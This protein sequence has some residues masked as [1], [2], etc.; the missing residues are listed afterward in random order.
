MRVTSFFTF[1]FTA[2]ATETVGAQG[3]FRG[4]NNGNHVRALFEEVTMSA[5]LSLSLPFGEVTMSADLSLSLPFDGVPEPA[6]DPEPSGKSGKGSSM[7][8]MGKSGKGSSM[9]SMGKSGKGGSMMT[10]KPTT[11]PTPPPTLTSMQKCLLGLKLS[12]FNLFQTEKYN[13]WMDNAT[14]FELAETGV[15]RKLHMNLILVFIERPHHD[16]LL[17]APLLHNPKLW[18][19]PKDIAEYVLFTITP[20]VVLKYESLVSTFLS[21]FE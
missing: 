18:K 15:R 12:Q 16:S 7:M 10:K 5:D 17:I 1:L 4:G 21:T 19:G 20:A 8:S 13:Q 11:T 9:M 2:I 14:T 3:I 6:S